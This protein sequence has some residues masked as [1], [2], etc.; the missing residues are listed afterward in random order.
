MCTL[1]G[2]FFWR[3]CVMNGRTDRC[4]T[5]D[6]ASRGGRSARWPPKLDSSTTTTSKAAF[7]KALVCSL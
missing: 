5:I 2:F 3:V 6:M 7:L 1:K 4:W